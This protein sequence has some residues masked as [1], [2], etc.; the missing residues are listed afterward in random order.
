MLAQ[1]TSVQLEADELAGLVRFCEE[2]LPAFREAAGFKG[3]YLLNDRQSGKVV[4]ISLW[5]SD[6]DRRQ[7]EAKG[8]QVRKEAG[9]ELGIAPPPVDL[10]EVVVRA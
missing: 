3:F 5:N 9:A 10:Y 1:I 6:D 2:K 4:T 8:A 7:H